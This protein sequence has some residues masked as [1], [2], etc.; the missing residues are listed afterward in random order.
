MSTI[1]ETFWSS[2]TFAV[3]AR[4]SATR[5]LPSAILSAMWPSSLK[6][7][8]RSSI[9][10][11]YVSDGFPIVVKP[12]AGMPALRNISPCSLLKAL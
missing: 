8:S 12:T 3:R 11:V 4:A 10:S 9:H 2:G 7:S 5:S 6:T 1:V